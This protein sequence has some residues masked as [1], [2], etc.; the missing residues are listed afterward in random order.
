MKIFDK[1]TKTLVIFAD[2]AELT[3]EVDDK[4]YAEARKFVRVS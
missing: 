1:T 2:D 3:S 4:V